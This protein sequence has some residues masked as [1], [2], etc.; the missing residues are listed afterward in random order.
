M[1]RNTRRAVALV[2]ISTCWVMF[3]ISAAQA[4]GVPAT[5]AKAFSPAAIV[6]GGTSTITFT[7]GNANVAVALNNASFT[8]T[9]SAMAISGAQAAGGTCTGAGTNNFADTTTALGFS[10]IT[11]PANSNC[12]VTILVTSSTIGAQPNSTSAVTSSIGLTGTGSNTAIL[13][14]APSTPVRLQSFEVN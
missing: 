8:D 14:V 6:A 12:T 9:L 4:G 3:G 2:A 11:I 5:I 10:G 1:S 7:L 13:T